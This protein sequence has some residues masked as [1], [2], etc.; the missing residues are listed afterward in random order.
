MKSLRGPSAPD[1]S[2]IS[3]FFAVYNERDA[4]IGI[5]TSVRRNNV[6]TFSDTVCK[7]TRDVKQLFNM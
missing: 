6:I 4:L 5:G 7:L 1:C 2:N 3:K